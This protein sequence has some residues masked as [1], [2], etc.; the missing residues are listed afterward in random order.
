MIQ[1]LDDPENAVTQDRRSRQHEGT[2]EISRW[3]AF[4]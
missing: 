4:H 3:A 2:V 1:A